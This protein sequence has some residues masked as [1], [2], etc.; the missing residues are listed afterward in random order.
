L[1]DLERK[2][3]FW[4]IWIRDIF[5]DINPAK[6]SAVAMFCSSYPLKSLARAAI[7]ENNSIIILPCFNSEI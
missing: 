1:G 5:V 2:F 3:T 7:E 6:A 4:R